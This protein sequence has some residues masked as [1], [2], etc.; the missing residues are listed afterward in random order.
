M[1]IAAANTAGLFPGQGSHGPGMRELVESERPDLIELAE[2]EADGDPFERAGDDTRYAQV[3]IYCAS[4]A[5]WETLPEPR[6]SLLA[7]HSLGEI[8]A[9]VAGEA[10][11]A[12]DGLRLVAA[13]G[14]LMSA[15][16]AHAPGGMVA[17]RLGADEARPLALRHGL[18]VANENA[19]GQV[20]LSGP[21]GAL[22]R[23]EA[24]APDLGLRPLRL[25]VR[26]GFHSPAMESALPSF[27]D[28]L[29]AVEI[30]PARATVISCLTAAPFQDPRRE[31]A[32]ALVSPVR[33][34]E[35]MIALGARGATRFV[36]VGPGKVLAGLA[37]RCLDGVEACSF[38]DLAVGAHA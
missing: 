30:A 20:V 3:A 8:S 27:R 29:A 1:A 12:A 25:P 28:A 17:L 14:R 37:R 31:L 7:G 21:E 9:L 36:E 24:E 18:C 2:R 38:S 32:D 35:V 16:H 19:P 10:L 6:P 26:G 15:A 23:L 33:W 5:A 34:R 13:R 11:S 4:L 22:A